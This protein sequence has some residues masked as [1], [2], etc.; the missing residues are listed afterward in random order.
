MEILFS[1]VIANAESNNSIDYDNVM[2][3][4][5]DDKNIVL[6]MSHGINYNNNNIFQAR[7][8]KIKNNVLSG[9]LLRLVN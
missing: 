6:K 1:K 7:Y 5:L 9:S 8:K 3:N 2:Y 4:T